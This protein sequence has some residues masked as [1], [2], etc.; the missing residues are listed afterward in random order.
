MDTPHHKSCETI[1]PRL[2][3]Y[4][5]ILANVEA[6][7]EEYVAILANS[8]DAES[9]RLYADA[10]GQFGITNDSADLSDVRKIMESPLVN[11]E[12]IA[13]ALFHQRQ[14]EME[15]CVGALRMRVN[16]KKTNTRFEAVVCRSPVH[17]KLFP[18]D[19]EEANV[20][21]SPIT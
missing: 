13:E 21:R 11:Y 3:L 4:G 16:D 18:G 9:V 2:R 20:T 12:E 14:A 7:R 5:E 15:F 8:L 17:N 10:L 6:Q 1:C 19:T